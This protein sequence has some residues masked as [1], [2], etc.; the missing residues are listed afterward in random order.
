MEIDLSWLTD[1]FKYW[2]GFPDPDNR[3][4][5]NIWEDF[6]LFDGHWIELQNRRDWYQS[7]NVPSIYEDHKYIFNQNM[8]MAK[9]EERYFKQNVDN[10]KFRSH[11]VVGE[12]LPSG[13]GELRIKTK[14]RTKSAPSGENNFC[15]VQYRVFTE[16]KYD[17]P[18]GV[19]FLPRIISRPLNQFFK[20][21]FLRYI[22]EEIIEYDSEYAR[23]RS[24]EYF[25]YLR[26]YHGEEPIQSKSRQAEFKPMPEDGVF[27]Q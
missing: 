19:V 12:E 7:P 13:K 4:E 23:E 27:F 18:Q 14:I 2:F 1:G 5:D 6:H 11:M 21:A 8:S 20:S 9:P 10:G 25:Q 22:G 15:M 16:I 17:M 24:T 26:K 3:D